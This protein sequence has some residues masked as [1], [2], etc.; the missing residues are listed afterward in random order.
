VGRQRLYFRVRDLE[1]HHERV[2]ACKG[3]PGAIERTAWMTMFA[4][5][6]PDGH[7]IVFA[8]TDPAIHAIDPW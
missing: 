2:L 8:E 1:A 7:E 5:T 3:R 4:V 6:D